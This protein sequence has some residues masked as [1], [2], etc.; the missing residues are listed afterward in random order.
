MRT[1]GYK[2]RH[3]T[4]LAVLLRHQ[5]LVEGRELDEQAGIGQPEVG[6]EGGNRTTVDIPVERELDRLVLPRDAVEVEDAGEAPLGIVSE[7]N[8]LGLDVGRHC[9]HDGT[10]PPATSPPASIEE[11]ASIGRPRGCGARVAA[12]SFVDLQDGRVQLGHHTRQRQDVEHTL[13]A[14]KK[15]DKLTVGVG[16]HRPALHQAPAVQ[17]RH[18]CPDHRAGIRRLDEPAAA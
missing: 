11:P 18:R 10:Q 13:G 17:R 8:R 5:P 14:G 7:A 2:Q 4:D 15:V 12:R 9:V 1:S 3:S 6:T 16:E